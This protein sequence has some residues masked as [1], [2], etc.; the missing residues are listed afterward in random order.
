METLS[1]LT[2]AD[3]ADGICLRAGR[4]AAAEAELLPWIAEFDRREGWAGAGLLSCAH[5]LSWRIGLSL[6]AAREQ[7]RVARRLEQLLALAEAFAGGRVSYSKVR[8]ITRVAEPG[9]GIDWVE[10]ARHC[11]AAQLES[12][13]RGVRRARANEEA[14]ADPEAA[15]W[16][17]RTRTRHND[18]GSFSMT[19]S[20]PAEL[21]PV[22]QAGIEAKK[23]ELQRQRDAESVAASAAA[24]PTRS[25]QAQDVPA[26]TSAPASEDVASQA[27]EAEPDSE[28]DAVDVP[29]GTSSA[30]LDAQADGWPPGT[31]VREV[32]AAV[33]S[34]AES[35]PRWQESGDAV[36]PERG[37]EGVPSSP[38]VEP[39]DDPFTSADAPAAKVTDAEALLSLAQDALA[40]EQAAH[41]A[42]ARRRRV[43]LTAQIDPLSGWGRLADGELLPATSLREVRRTL[44]GRDGTLRLRPVTAADL[45]RHDLGRTQREANSALRDLL[46]TLDGE[47]CRFPGCTRP[48]KLHAHH[49]RYWIDGGGTDLAN[50]VLVC[51][52][53]HTL[54]H[55]QGF[56]LDLNPDRR[57]E[58]LT[59][60]GVAVLHHPAQPWGD[61]ADL[62]TGRGQSVSAGTLPPDHCTARLDLGYAVNVLLAQAA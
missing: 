52:R 9:D 29:A 37:V 41:P 57:L 7:V 8:A 31:T 14:Q 2:D 61:P 45:R 39:T 40:A 3:L 22:I 16:A 21:L 54:I 1:A 35:V 53:H 34:F 18:D 28:S 55:G 42:I 60:D 12:L 10:H 33:S 47:R 56:A 32:R 23:A 11:S 50:L 62:A 44:P 51:A 6:G 24:A 48:T 27:E 20:G 59:A 38:P 43:R 4:I 49:V 17:L 30:D 25:P 5:W 15:Q 58:V 46:G 26:G 13:V 19:I 36:A